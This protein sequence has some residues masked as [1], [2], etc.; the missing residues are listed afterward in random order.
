MQSSDKEVH[1]YIV[2]LRRSQPSIQQRLFDLLWHLRI[3]QN[4]LIPEFH[5]VKFQ[6]LEFRQVA[7]TL[8]PLLA[9]LNAEFVND[10]EVQSLLAGYLVALVAFQ[11][12][13]NKGPLPLF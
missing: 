5:A 3:H 10:K 2:L 1:R 13:S 6:D 12:R 8:F 4:V 7:K 9:E 11:N